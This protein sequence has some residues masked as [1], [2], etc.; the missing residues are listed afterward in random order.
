MEK[1]PEPYKFIVTIVDMKSQPCRAGH[2]VGDSW[3]F[4]YCT[5]LGMCGEA[6]HAIYPLIHAM[7]LGADL[8]GYQ[9]QEHRGDPDV[10]YAWCPDEGWVKFEVRRV[11]QQQ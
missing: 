7:R 5:P 8:T 6:F 10:T 9:A 4:E 2:R 11:R 3:E 1:Y